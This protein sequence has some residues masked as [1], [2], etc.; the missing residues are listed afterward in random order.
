MEA[1]YFNDVEIRDKE[2]TT[3]RERLE[4]SEENSNINS[5]EADEIKRGFSCFEKFSVGFF[6]L[7]HHPGGC[8]RRWCNASDQR[9]D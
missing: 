8:I 1:E 9:V 5:I 4:E 3:L 6:I 2:L 7:D